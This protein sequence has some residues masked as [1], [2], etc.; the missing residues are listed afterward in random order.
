MAFSSKGGFMKKTMIL[1]AML[2]ASVSVYANCVNG[3]N[4]QFYCNWGT[5]SPCGK[6]STTYAEN[7]ATAVCV[8][9]GT[10]I[11]EVENCWKYGSGLYLDAACA[12]D[13][14]NSCGSGY[15]DGE[16]TCTVIQEVA[17]E[18]CSGNYC[19]W[20]TCGPVTT[21]KGAA[22]PITTCEAAI[23]NCATN[24]S[25]HTVYSDAACTTPIDGEPVDPG[26]PVDPGTPPTSS[27]TGYK[28]FAYDI[29]N[30]TTDSKG[31]ES[32]SAWG[33]DVIVY[34]YGKTKAT[35][36]NPTNPH[37][38]SA[39]LSVDQGVIKLRGV[40]G[41]AGEPDIYSGAF[42]GVK[43]GGT[44]KNITD[45]TEGFSYWYKGDAH[46]FLL[47]F[48]GTVCGG[49]ADGD[50]S[51]K[52]GI[53]ITPASTGWT[54]KTVTISQFTLTNT[55]TGSECTTAAN[56]TV[57]LD[58]VQQMVWGFDD[59]TTGV[60]LMVADVVCL[61]SS[62]ENYSTAAPSDAITVNTGYFGGGSEPPVQPIRIAH[63]VQGN[64]LT[65]MQNAVNLQS[66]G[67]AKIQIFDLKGKAVRT[68]T[69]SQGSYVVPLSGLPKGLYIV[70]ASNSSWKQTIKVTVK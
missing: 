70:K 55:W 19:K 22:T 9:A 31:A 32:E 63:A 13:I 10:K 39:S 60:N 51:N 58:K 35:I 12:T 65:A 68:Q 17:D 43:A 16:F 6:I 34:T 56:G 41:L 36:T 2:L 45:C 27:G 28:I 15:P 66:T 25:S 26:G 38:T 3:E 61:T 64:T 14:R 1:A 62:G 23:T 24:S 47:D 40:A 8:T 4:Q 46:W 50:G 5:T 33:T 52:W 7:P 11:G 18:V 49:T 69:F 57:Q 37:Y 53:K 54:Q 67:N 29:D 30:T 59:K 42:I 21:D 44:T 48:P 20:D